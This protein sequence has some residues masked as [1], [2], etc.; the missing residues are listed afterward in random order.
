M[1]KST[2]IGARTTPEF[3]KLFLRACKEAGVEPSSIVR[4]LLEDLLIAKGYELPIDPKVAKAR[5]AI[6]KP[7]KPKAEDGE[8]AREIRAV[9]AA[10]SPMTDGLTFDERQ[11][12]EAAML[13]PAAKK[14][15]AEVR[16]SHR[17]GSKR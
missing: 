9:L 17:K 3:A 12:A 1:P 15:F 8:L 6:A 14:R 5:A 4:T 10:P 2:T 16:A 13:S 7:A 11:K